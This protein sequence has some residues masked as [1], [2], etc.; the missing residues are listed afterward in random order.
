MR[1]VAAV[2]SKAVVRVPLRLTNSAA[3]TC[4]HGAGV[5]FPPFHHVK[6]SNARTHRLD[7]FRVRLFQVLQL[8]DDALQPVHVFDRLLQLR[9]RRNACRCA[10]CV[11]AHHTRLVTA[12]DTLRNLGYRGGN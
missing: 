6:Q 1:P 11:P 7:E 5:F 2:A 3:A 12:A 10:V 8:C 4:A 9:V